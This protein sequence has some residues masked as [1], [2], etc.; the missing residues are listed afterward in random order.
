LEESYTQNAPQGGEIAPH[1]VL[2]APSFPGIFAN[3][4]ALQPAVRFGGPKPTPT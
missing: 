2:F 3:A 1:A 4:A